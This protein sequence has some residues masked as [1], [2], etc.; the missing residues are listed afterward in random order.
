MRPSN[1]QSLARIV[2]EPGRMLR[3][4]VCPLSGREEGIRLQGLGA[5]TPRLPARQYLL[6]PAYGGPDA[7]VIEIVST[8]HP[9]ALVASSD[10][11]RKRNV[12]V[13]PFTV[14]PRLIIV[15]M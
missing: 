5:I 13:C 4:R 1:R 11:K 9:G 12:M 6:E 3:A 8:F 7:P 14:G 2:T 15:V 10:P